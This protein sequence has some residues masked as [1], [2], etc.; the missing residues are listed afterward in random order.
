M[1]I[2]FYD[3]R[4]SED[5]RTFLIKEKAVNYEAGNMRHPKDVTLMLQNLL[6]M[7]V[8]AEEY[9][10]LIALNSTCRIL[11]VCLL[12]KGTINASLVSPREVYLRAVLLGAAHIILCHNHPS[13][14][15]TPSDHDIKLT[16]RI[17]EAGILLDIHLSDHIIIGRDNYF[18]FAEH[19]LL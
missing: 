16:E 6:H 12:S 10:Y 2:T 11:G 14:N 1:R 4:L 17:K 15:T 18:S 3:T 5:Y 7:D 19:K 8:L 9:C 13:G